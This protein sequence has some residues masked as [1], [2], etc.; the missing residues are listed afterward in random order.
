M[1]F[2]IRNDKIHRTT[3]FIKTTCINYQKLN[4]S[5]EQNP[6]ESIGKHIEEQYE[7]FVS[8]LNQCIEMCKYTKAHISKQQ[9]LSNKWIKIH[10]ELLLLIKEKNRLFKKMKQNDNELLRQ[11]YTVLGNE[12]TNKRRQLKK[13]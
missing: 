11:Q 3:A 2:P 4:D 7:D 6:I 8:K 10:K 12:V 1:T 9:P 5:L 13:H